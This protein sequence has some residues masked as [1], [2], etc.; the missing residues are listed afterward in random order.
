[1]G[2]KNR[3]ST[4]ALR[5]VGGLILFVFGFL[6][7]IVPVLLDRLDGTVVPSSL[8][9]GGDHMQPTQFLNRPDGAIAF[10]DSGGAGPLV[11]CVPGLG[12]L[13]QEYR[14]LAPQLV[15]AGFRVVTMDLRGH[16]ESSVGW[17]S[18]STSAV[19]SDIVAL[20]EHL[21]AGPA[22]I[23]GTSMA[24]GS[25]VWAATEAPD[26]IAGQVLIGPFVRAGKMSF[27]DTLMIRL[28]MARPWG[29]PAW[30]MFY[31][32]LYP[33]SPPTDLTA[34]RGA[35]K[36]NL[37]EPGR[38]A[39]VQ[40]MMWRPKEDIEERLAKVTAPSL[41]VM[42]TKDPDFKDPGPEA[43]AR[44]LADQVAG[45]VLMVEGAGHYPHAEMP[46]EV[47]PQIIAFLQQHRQGR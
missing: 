26:L 37:R 28:A 29:V 2:K 18:Y 35:L 44:W 34:Y 40:G 38:F 41:V 43:E 16:G 4:R 46:L 10:D 20:V 21:N 1:M 22:F 9:Q 25:A 3:S 33:T 13:R 17:P 23:V 30:S 36:Q 15:A 14:F 31:Q 19:G 47:G 11:V 45:A 6:Y 27:V 24:A 32:S 8:T 39:A 5:I 12:D 42:G 7:L